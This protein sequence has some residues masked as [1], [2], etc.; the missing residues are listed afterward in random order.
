MTSATSL[1]LIAVGAILAFAVSYE[2][3]G[4]SIKTV[5]VILIVVGGMGLA[6]AMATL[7]GYAPWGANRSGT[8]QPAANVTVANNTAPPAAVTPPPIATPPANV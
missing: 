5:G 2:V 4:I 8:A 7:A 3:A 6:F 1:L